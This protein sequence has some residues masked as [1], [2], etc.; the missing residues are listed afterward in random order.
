MSKNIINEEEVKDNNNKNKINEIKI[1][2]GKIKENG[3]NE[4]IIENK[5]IEKGK[6]NIINENKII[7][8]EEEEQFKTINEK[9]YELKMN[10]IKYLLTITLDD[11]YITF[12][13]S[14]MNE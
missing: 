2:K 11:K 3:I 4:N 5:I 8:N 10:K 6:E 7:E 12:S 1:S 14:P 13:L 9:E